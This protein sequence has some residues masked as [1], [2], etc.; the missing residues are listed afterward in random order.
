M[1]ESSRVV[2]IANPL[3]ERARNFVK[4]C[5]SLSLPNCVQ[6]YNNINL[7]EGDIVKIEPIETSI[8]KISDLPK[9]TGAYIEALQKLNTYKDIK[10]L[11]SP[12]VIMDCLDK[13]KAKQ[14]ITTTNS[15]IM[16][17]PLIDK[18]FSCYKELVDYMIT[19][20]KLQVFV[21]PRYGGGAGGIIA[22]RLNLKSGQVVAY[23]TIN[24]LNQ[25]C[26]NSKKIRKYTNV[27][28]IKTI[29]ECVLSIGAVVE[30]W[31]P[32]L[33]IDGTKV[34][35]RAVVI[36]GQCEFILARGSK[37]TITNLHLNNCPITTLNGLPL[38]KIKDIAVKTTQCF[39]DMLY[40]GVDILLTP[41]KKAYVIEINSQGDSIH[42]N[43]NNGNT[44]YKKQLQICSKMLQSK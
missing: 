39:K 13:K 11:N 17:T 22:F 25:E 36:N 32:K 21:K 18:N 3:G 41:D 20:K 27:D 4:E 34:D 12:Q 1:S 6:D 40:A 24:I 43:Y 44:I 15:G 42:S 23:S 28:D 2:L 29:V 33:N 9:F 5:K 10:F 26:H 35:F 7:V 30:E 38:E 14:I 31:I 37:N 8:S 16:L 19:Y